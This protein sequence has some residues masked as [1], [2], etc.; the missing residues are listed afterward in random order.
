M[1]IPF[2]RGI[3]AI[4]SRGDLLCRVRPEWQ[5]AFSALYGKCCALAGVD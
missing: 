3:A 1:T 5:K 4:Q 2:E